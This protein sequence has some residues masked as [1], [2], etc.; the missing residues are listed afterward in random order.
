MNNLTEQ[1]FARALKEIMAKKGYETL[2]DF[3]GKLHYID[4]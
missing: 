2:E 1:A 4:R 3:R